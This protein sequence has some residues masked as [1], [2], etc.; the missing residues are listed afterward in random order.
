MAMQE[1][2]IRKHKKT[3]IPQRKMGFMDFFSLSFGSREGSFW[4]LWRPPCH[5]RVDVFFSP[6]PDR[7]VIFFFPFLFPRPHID[8]GGLPPP[9][10]KLV[11]HR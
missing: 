7:I 5:A 3:P 4:G 1:K 2:N 9:V 10:R 11:T 6:H 8:L